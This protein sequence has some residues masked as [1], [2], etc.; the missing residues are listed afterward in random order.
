MW[1]QRLIFLCLAV[2]V[3]IRCAGGEMLSADGGAEIQEERNYIALTFDD[4][5]RRST[6]T[7]LLD[8]LR[9]RGA[10][11]TFFL[12]GEQIEANQ[13]LVERMK[14]EGHQVGNHT[15]SHVKL[16][17][18]DAGTVLW[19]VEETDKLLHSVLGEGSYWLRPPY[20]RL[21]EAQKQGMKVPLITWSIDS[22]DW[23]SMNAAKAAQ[24]VLR[25]ARPNAIV[26]MHDIYQMCI[27][28]SRY[29]VEGDL[30]RQ[31]A[32]DIKRL[33]E[34]GCY[35]GIRHRRGL[36]VRGQRS[37]TNARTRKGP[38]KTIANKKK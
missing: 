24:T 19:E 23:E 18:A 10:S 5:P 27:R 17:G 14:A 36:P 15:W 35:R 1:R 12:I 8:G 28:D 26:L 29:T 3:T 22:R 37:K 6:T 2:L 34:I 9:E 31:T 4:G 38:K 33:T 20:G 16:E 21:E 13:D 32:L 30:R 25:E 11:A 7:R